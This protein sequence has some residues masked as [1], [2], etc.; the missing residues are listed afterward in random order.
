MST[1]EVAQVGDVSSF[2]TVPPLWGCGWRGDTLSTLR[3]GSIGAAEAAKGAGEG[4]T[5]DGGGDECEMMC[6][7]SPL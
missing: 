7:L 4:A 3:S 1:P 5:C 6:I 2:D